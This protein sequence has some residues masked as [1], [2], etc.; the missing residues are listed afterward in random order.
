MSLLQSLMKTIRSWRRRRGG[1]KT[2]KGAGI[3]VEQLD[4][5][6]LLAVNFTGNVMIDFPAPNG[7]GVVV[8]PANVDPM[9]PNADQVAEIPDYL[10]SLVPVSGFNLSAIWVSYDPIQDILSIG[11]DQPDSGRGTNNDVIAGDADDN[12]N[13]GN[14]AFPTPPLPPPVDPAVAAAVLMETG[15]EFKDFADMAGSEGMFIF[16]DLN[17]DNTAD[18]VAGFSNDPLRPSFEVARAINP[19]PGTAPTFGVPLP[20]FQGS[21]YLNNDPQHPNLQFQITRFSELYLAETGE[22]LKPNTTFGIGAFAGSDADDG[23]SSTFLKFKSFVLDDATEPDTCPPIV[24]NPH[25]GR[26]VNTAHP[27]DV[28]VHVLGGPNFNV[29]D[30]NPDTVTLEGAPSYLDFEK[31]VN[32]DRFPDRTF[33]FNS[34]ELDDLPGGL[35]DAVLIGELENGIRFHGSQPIFVRNDSFYSKPDLAIRDAKREAG[36]LHALLTPLQQELFHNGLL[37]V[38]ATTAA[39]APEPVVLTREAPATVKI[40]Q[41]VPVP[42]SRKMPVGPRGVVP[43]VAIPTRTKTPIQDTF[44]TT[45]PTVKIPRISDRAQKSPNLRVVMNPAS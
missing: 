5:R 21:F 37:E 35:V 36:N 4:H 44:P 39:R 12:G 24:I 19:I 10:Q 7:P 38:E 26:H 22:K 20:Q 23:I 29:R 43:Q 32:H 41:R 3:A 11:L 40:T 33:V 27:T 18:I 42:G 25:S 13:S 31:N 15:F 1:P 28:R 45:A 34:L 17:Q 16:L 30:I 8:L 14:P 6:Q 2:R 9:D